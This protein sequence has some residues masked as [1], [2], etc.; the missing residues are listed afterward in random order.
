M[1]TF[2]DLHTRTPGNKS[3]LK[4]YDIYAAP[5]EEWAR[6]NSCLEVGHGCHRM[7]QGLKMRG[8]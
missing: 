7:Y 2:L 5:Q 1:A 4:K 6:R 3:E 8:R